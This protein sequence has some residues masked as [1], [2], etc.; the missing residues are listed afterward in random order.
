MDKN[1]STDYIKL[2]IQKRNKYTKERGKK[3]MKSK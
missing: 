2:I 3:K 1:K